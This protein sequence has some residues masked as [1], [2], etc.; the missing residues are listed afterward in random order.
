MSLKHLEKLRVIGG[1]DMFPVIYPE[2]NL[3]M[4]KSA[5]PK[6]GDVV[7][8]ANRY[9]VKIAHRLI[10]S[11]L[12]YYFT[13]GDNCPIFNFPCRRKDILGVVVGKCASVKCGFSLRFFL[14]LFLFYYIA[15]SSLFDVKKKKVFLSLDIISRI[16]APLEDIHYP[17]F[18]DNSYLNK[19]VYGIKHV[20]KSF[21]GYYARKARDNGI[22]PESKFMFTGNPEKIYLNY[23]SLANP[24]SAKESFLVKNA[25]APG[26]FKELYKYCIELFEKEFITLKDI[27]N[28]RQILSKLDLDKIE[29]KTKGVYELIGL[30]LIIMYLF[31][32]KYNPGK[33]DIDLSNFIK[34]HYD[35]LIP[36]ISKYVESVN[37]DM[38]IHLLHFYNSMQIFKIYRFLRAPRGHNP[39]SQRYKLFNP[40]VWL[41]VKLKQRRI[42]KYMEK[43]L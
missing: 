41:F 16:L 42:H 33:K 6:Q 34:K 21:F 37:Y 36:S 25:H 1:D 8:F 10:H 19:V 31:D 12:G 13:R 22:L 24:V 35:K 2:E 38:P 23:I 40:I 32:I 3:L 5:E 15:Y 30:P 14:N 28:L 17:D 20:P 39:E 27:M 11:F 43:R 26:Y 29:L 7:L 4:D 9:G 18:Y